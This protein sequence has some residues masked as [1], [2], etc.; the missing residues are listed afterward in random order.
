MKRLC[1]LKAANEVSI[2]HY[3]SSIS[4]KR[5]KFIIFAVL[6]VYVTAM[7]EE[8]CMDLKESKDGYK[9][10]LGEEEM[11]KKNDMIRLEFQKISASFFLVQ[12]FLFQI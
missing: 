2:A 12:V 3:Y 9:R 6:F 4:R 1:Y 7:T 10:W 8:S 5:L 11:E